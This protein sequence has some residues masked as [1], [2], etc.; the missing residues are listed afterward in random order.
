MQSGASRRPDLVT[1]NQRTTNDGMVVRNRILMGLPQ[2]EFNSLRP[3]LEWLRLPERSSLYEPGDSPDYA[4]FPNRG[5]ISRVVAMK[6]GKTVEVGVTGDEGLIGAEGISGLGTSPHRLI[7]YNDGDGARIRIDVL[8][9]LLPMLPQFQFMLTRHVLLQSLQSAQWA[10]CNRLHNAEQRLARW[11]LTM[12]DRAE[13]D[14]LRVTHD[15]LAS[16]LGTDR[17]SVSLAAGLLQ[18]KEAITYSRGSIKIL[19][20]Q[21]LQESVCECHEVMQRLNDPLDLA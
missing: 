12:H 2:T 15:F 6:D 1:A 4:Y 11:L 10:A 8:R 19:D 3:A 21:R 18:R 5:L 14:S 16:M 7:L 20:R 17:P 9:S 13:E